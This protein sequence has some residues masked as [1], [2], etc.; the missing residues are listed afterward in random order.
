[1]SSTWSRSRSASYFNDC[2]SLSRWAFVI[3]AFL[4]LSSSSYSSLCANTRSTS[5]MKFHAF[6]DFFWLQKN[7][8]TIFSNEKHSQTQQVCFYVTF[9][10]LFLIYTSF[11][12]HT[13]YLASRLSWLWWCY[14]CYSAEFC[15]WREQCSHSEHLVSQWL[16]WMWLSRWWWQNKTCVIQLTTSDVNDMTIERFT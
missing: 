5:L 10:Q 7:S 11:F 16:Q 2:F 4:Y 14:K 12:P 13:V 15:Q 8:P 3:I 1:M 6:S 9:N